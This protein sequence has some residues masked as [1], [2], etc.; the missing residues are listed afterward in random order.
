[1]IVGTHTV[2]DLINYNTEHIEDIEYVKDVLI[3]SAQE[4]G[5]HVVDSLFYKFEP[6]GISG[7]LILS[8][9][10]IT[11]HTWPEYKF[12]A[13]DAFTCSK[14]IKPENFCK[15]L[16]QKIGASIV[17]IKNLERGFA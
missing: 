6:I 4:V 5:L 1:M 3:S 16:A 13:L 15:L 10:H 7:V 8:E 12:V 17:N 11:I 9:S 2:V 14:N